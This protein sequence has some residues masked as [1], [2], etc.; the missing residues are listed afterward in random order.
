LAKRVDSW[1]MAGIK[2]DLLCLGR[3]RLGNDQFHHL[4]EIDHRQVRLIFGS[5]QGLTLIDHIVER[6]V[7]EGGR[8]SP[9]LRYATDPQS[10]IVLNDESGR[11]F[12]IRPDIKWTPNPA[13]ATAIN[14]VNVRT[15]TVRKLLSFDV[16][17]EF[18]PIY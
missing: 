7:L 8:C 13:G 12:G 4:I 2:S 9:D 5:E 1:L 10:G 18:E 3:R 16:V 11:I 14:D 6:I 17:V 15:D